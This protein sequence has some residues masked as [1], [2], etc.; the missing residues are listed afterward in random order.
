MKSL[1]AGCAALL[2]SAVLLPTTAS[3]DRHYD[4]GVCGRPV[5][6]SAPVRHPQHCQPRYHDRH[7]YGYGSGYG[8]GYS[9]YRHGVYRYSGY[10][11]NPYGYGSYGYGRSYGCDRPRTSFSITVVR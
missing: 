4:R 6:R 11:S 5:Y 1:L 2:A 3:A 8:Y 7:A 10:G 9:P